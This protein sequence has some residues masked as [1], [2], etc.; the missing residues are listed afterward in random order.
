MSHGLQVGYPSICA[1]LGRS[2]A[3]DKRRAPGLNLCGI[4]PAPLASARYLRAGM[5]A[6]GQ[7]NKALARSERL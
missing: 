1:G 7:S 4:S 3:D 2:Q 6:M 5:T